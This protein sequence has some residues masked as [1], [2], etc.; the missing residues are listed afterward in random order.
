[1]NNMSKMNGGSKMYMGPLDSTSGW[2]MLMEEGR[3]LFQERLCQQG[4]ADHGYWEDA[5][6]DGVEML[7]HSKGRPTFPYG[8]AFDHLVRWAEGRL[9]ELLAEQAHCWSLDELVAMRP[10]RLR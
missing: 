7:L 9:R 10:I 4:M 8:V 2:A 1:M 5:F 3:K 6:M